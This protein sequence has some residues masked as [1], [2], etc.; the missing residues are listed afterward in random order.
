MDI[1]Q[2]NARFALPGRLQAVAGPGGLPMLDLDSGAARAR[3][4]I[5][6]GQVLAFRPA[7]QAEDL[8]FASANAYYTPG[9]AI[10]GGIPVC[11]PWFGP[12]PEGL[13]R[14]AHG[15]VRTRSWQLLET[16]ALA[17]G[18]VRVRLGLSDSEE[19]RAIWP[20]TF[21]LELQ[22]T[23]GETLTTA[24]VTRNRGDT[25]FTLSQALH[26]YLRVGDIDRVQVRGLEATR[27]LDKLDRGTE[28]RQ[29][30][31]VRISGEVDRIYTGVPPELA[32]ED[33]ALGRRI[34]IRSTGSTSAVVWNPWAAGAAAMADLDATDY[35]RMLCVETTNAGPDLVQV[36]PGAEHRLAA[37]Y[38]ISPL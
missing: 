6:A 26:S 2:I 9:K 21:A 19:T 11:W 7:G 32:I 37:E 33:A 27:Y 23:V 30:G 34:F 24:L 15:F 35:R 13:G 8:L 14:P 16:E 29:E 22:A 12:D 1:G 28:K 18:R 10:K 3:I 25:A 20:R 4:S 31:P 38:S 5:Y 36:A 17:D